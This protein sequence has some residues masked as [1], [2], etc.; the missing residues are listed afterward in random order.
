M[1]SYTKTYIQILNKYHRNWH[2]NQVQWG[3]SVNYFR[4]VKALDFQF[5]INWEKKGTLSK[6]GKATP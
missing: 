4:C 5:V 2:A 1:K 3:S 6:T